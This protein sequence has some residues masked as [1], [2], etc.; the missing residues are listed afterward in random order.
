MFEA[1]LLIDNSWVILLAANLTN[2][3]P[4][5]GIFRPFI[6]CFPLVLFF[7]SLFI[8]AF[9]ELHEHVLNLHFDLSVMFSSVSLAFLVVALVYYII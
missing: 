2:L 7:I 4:V 1:K 5:I 8:S 6:F 9:C 3:C